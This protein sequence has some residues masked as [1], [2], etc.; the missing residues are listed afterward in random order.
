MVSLKQAV[1]CRLSLTAGSGQ[2]GSV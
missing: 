1:Q 2:H